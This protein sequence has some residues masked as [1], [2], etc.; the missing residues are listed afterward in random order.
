MYYKAGAV[1]TRNDL[2]DAVLL[3]VGRKV[4]RPHVLLHYAH[5]GQLLMDERK[6]GGWRK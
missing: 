4:A 5:V 2:K 1:L 6:D 3:H